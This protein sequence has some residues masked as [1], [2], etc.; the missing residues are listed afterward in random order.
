MKIKKKFLLLSSLFIFQFTFSQNQ[1]QNTRK[2]ITE[3]NYFELVIANNE[4]FEKR[5]ENRSTLNE[6][7]K[8]ALDKEYKKY[9]R[10]HS[11]WETRV[12][13]NG[14]MDSYDK[15]Y[16]SLK[17][18]KNKKDVE[19][20]IPKWSIIGP[21]IFPRG[22]NQSG[23]KGIG[24]IDAIT[25]NPKNKNHVIIGARSGGVWQTQNID[26]NSPTWV[27]LTDDL[28]IGTVNDVKIV[29]NTIYAASSNES[30]NFGGHGNS[31]Y[32]LGIIKKPLSGG[33]WYV[34]N[35][36]FDANK[37]AVASNTNI[38]YSLG[39]KH[40]YKSIDAGLNWI[41]TKNV[42]PEIEAS[43]ILLSHIEVNPINSNIVVVTGRVDV[44]SYSKVP[45]NNL[46][47]KTTDGGKTWENLTDSV[48]SLI[49]DKI[50][51]TKDVKVNLKKS[52][53]NA[54]ATY[55]YK[56]TLY[57]CLRSS[58]SKVYF[59]TAEKDWSNL[60]LYNSLSSKKRYAFSSDNMIQTFQ[61]VSK[62]E[63]LLGTRRLR[64][65]NNTKHN[66]TILDGYYNDLHQDIRAI[67][68]NAT[69]GR[70]LLGTDGSI[71]RTFDIDNNLKFSNF[72]NISGNLNLFLAFNMAYNNFGNFRTLRIGNQ[73]TGWY[74]NHNAGL[75]WLGWTR[76]EGIWGEGRVYADPKNASVIYF[77]KARSLHVSN[78][79][80]VSTSFTARRFGNY[81]RSQL[82]FNPNNSSQLVF[83]SNEYFNLKI[84]N[85][86]YALS[87]SND[88]MKSSI[89]ISNGIEK[90]KQG[91]N[92]AI[93]ISKSNSSV[94]Y[95]SR[96]EVRYSVDGINNT[97]YK[98]DNLNFNNPKSIT[99]TNLT[100]NLNKYDKTILSK[101]FIND[102]EVEDTNEHEIWLAFG[103]LE[104][105][106]KVY[107]SINGGVTWNNI[108]TNL[109]N[110]PVNTLAYDAVNNTLFA[111]T[112][113]GVYIY[114][115]AKDSWF[116]FGRNLP[117]SMVTSIA[118]DNHK[119]EIIAS[120]HGRSVWSAQLPN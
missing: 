13:E 15:E 77:N 107:H 103:N 22:K 14:N 95:V 98:T 97:L 110:T 58:I 85:Y 25:V 9:V 86:T 109:P 73:D 99:Y 78:N 23:L 115:N 41:K 43:K 76:T 55:N 18:I 35:E 83:D 39:S 32:G 64:V 50:N 20:N 81:N 48:E 87:L 49:N 102:I 42:I 59:I 47:F 91:I 56:G 96:K 4:K 69:T 108:S 72:P 118:I 27:S 7:E 94:M 90:L 92:T 88:Q 105:G 1:I 57:L 74:E 52:S 112:D 80:G 75:D 2:D 45:V 111:G 71:H 106:K 28:P 114:D 16:F 104:K 65:I 44:W 29:G 53:D 8:A 31:R 40:V 100:E 101:A 89:D 5:F 70:L 37:I 67:N 63:I 17:N 26:S 93:A 10:W 62:N 19:K 21:T 6:N 84:K 24:R 82:K 38:M 34:S 116:R 119:N 46:V 113:Y 3:N 66:E 36:K 61:V 68:Y 60:E 11:Y 79:G 120:T 33:K 117:V 30:A 51:A 12:D 54:I